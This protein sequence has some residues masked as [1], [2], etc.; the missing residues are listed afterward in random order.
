MKKDRAVQFRSSS[1]SGNALDR[2]WAEL[3]TI[4]ERLMTP[5]AEADDGRDPGRAEGVAFCLAQFYGS[6][7]INWVRAE[8]VKRWNLR[9]DQGR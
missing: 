4:M 5:G 1:D 7:G 8:A 6:R 2:M 3:D 9:L